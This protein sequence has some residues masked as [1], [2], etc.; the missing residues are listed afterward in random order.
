LLLDQD[1]L[2]VEVQVSEE[3]IKDGSEMVESL[4]AQEAVK[5]VAWRKALH[6][7]P[8]K[9]FLQVAQDELKTGVTHMV[10]TYHSCTVYCS[11]AFRA[12]LT[13]YDRAAEDVKDTY[14]KPYILAA[15]D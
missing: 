8:H 6:R 9:T 5:L 2:G 14:Y 12:S 10:A 13:T 3:A 1:V 4:S 11:E 15:G 7:I